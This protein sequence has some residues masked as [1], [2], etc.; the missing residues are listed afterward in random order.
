MG[1][2]HCYVTFHN[3]IFAHL[4]KRRSILPELRHRL[5]TP[6]HIACLLCCLLAG[7]ANAQT[8]FARDIE[9]LQN[10]GPLFPSRGIAA[11]DYNND[12]RV[13]VFLAENWREGRFALLHN[14]GQGRFIDRTDVIRLPISPQR[15][16]GGTIFGDYDNDGDLD[17]FLPTD[18][19]DLNKLLR[20]DRGLFEEVTREAGL[21]DSLKTDNAIWFDYD[22]DGFID[23]Y[24]GNLGGPEARNTLY[25]NN[26]NGGF[27]DATRQAGLDL[28]LSAERGG[29]TDGML[30]ADF[31]DD[32]WPDLYVGVFDYPNRLFLNDGQGGFR[33][34][35]TGEIGDPGEAFG[36]AAGDID[37]D[38]DLDLLVSGGRTLQ[39]FIFLNT[40]DGTFIAQTPP[41]GADQGAYFSAGDF[42]GDGFLDIAAADFAETFFY[43]NTPNDNHWLRVELNGRPSNR[44]GFGARLVATSGPLR[45]VRELLAGDGTTQ[46]EPVAHFGL[47]P[48]MQ[49]DSL[50][51]R[52]PSGQVDVLHELPVDRQIRVF[53]GRR[54]Y[55][56]VSPSV[57]SPTA[58]REGST[59]TLQVRPA[60]FE[61]DARIAAIEADL[62]DLGGPQV[63]PL[64]DA[65][66]GTWHLDTEFVVDVSNG[67]YSIWMMIDQD[68]FG[69]SHWVQLHR[70][71]AVLPVA[72]LSLLGADDWPVETTGGAEAPDFEAVDPV[73]S[74]RTTTAF[75]VA[76]TNFLGW[77][78]V[79]R[80]PRAVNPFGYTHLRFAFHTGDAEGRVLNLIIGGEEATKNVP[81]MGRQAREDRSID[82]AVA[83]WQVVEIPLVEVGIAEPITS[84][85]FNGDLEGTFYIDDLRLV[86]TASLPSTAVVEERVPSLPESFTLAQNYPN[87]FNSGTVLRFTLPTP[88]EVEL[89]LYNLA[90]QHVAVLVQGP[91]PAGTYTVRWDGR[92]EEG[93]ELASGLYL[94][95]LQ[96]GPQVQTRKLIL[97]R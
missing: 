83:D 71:I 6:C 3:Y 80:A 90:G 37:N 56:I 66:D 68:T 70:R 76:P 93:R 4:W 84:I 40:S 96:A 97:L 43:E 57:A 14:E 94:Y 74:E 47:G 11:G 92:D 41:T 23:L 25:R 46:N 51:V 18:A 89:V 50:E 10:I 24:L 8:S 22:R 54:Q 81:L 67:L 29:A 69:G 30:G 72:D 78:V 63:A 19:H 26:G 87:P 44:Q 34:A 39:L 82:L 52:W 31:D 85:T 16:G 2:P 38:G 64:V 58:L 7:S 45:Q 73:Q 86:A 15:K 77:S 91:R 36:A 61:P 28:Q 1:D 35:T 49:V 48:H 27:T 9:A 32:G 5:S 88:T 53:E 20:N 33:D 60:L 17:L 75:L 55:H 13:D 95:R 42:G 21:M 62:S 65:G 79:L 59:L 12:G